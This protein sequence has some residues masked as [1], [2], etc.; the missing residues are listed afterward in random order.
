MLNF[1]KTHAPLFIADCHLGKLSKYLRFMGYDTLYFPQI[2]DNDLIEL[3]NRD[4]RIV[5]TRDRELSERKKAHCILLQSVNTE[6][7]LQELMGTYD[8]KPESSSYSR[9]IICNEPLVKVDKQDVIEK[10][11]VKVIT[12]FSYFET[13]KQCGRIYWHGDHYKRMKATIERIS[14]SV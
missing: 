6:G 3:A 14:G 2:D 10:L 4:N 13:C 11:P 8:L 12:H 5:L 7:Q 9:C 1:K